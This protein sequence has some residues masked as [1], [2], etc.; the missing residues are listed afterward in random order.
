MKQ[1]CAVCKKEF[2]AANPKYDFHKCNEE[3]VKESI[4]RT[5]DIVWNE[6]EDTWVDTDAKLPTISVPGKSPFQ[7]LS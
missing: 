5:H 4:E 6:F 3:L 7:H 1:E 2:E